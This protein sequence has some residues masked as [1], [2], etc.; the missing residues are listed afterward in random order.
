MPSFDAGYYQLT[1]LIPVVRGADAA[2]QW[3]WHPLS[4]TA[5]DSLRE[6]LASFRSVDVPVPSDPA[7]RHCRA[8]PFSCSNRTHFARLVVLE[9]L[10]YNG[11]QQGDTLFDTVRQLLPGMKKQQ[12]ES[13]DYLPSPYLLVLLDFDALDG[14]TAMVEKYLLELWRSMEQEWTLILRHC[15]G[16]DS[17]PERRKQSFVRLILNHEI[18]TTFGYAT[19]AWL[20]RKRNATNWPFPAG[21]RQVQD[22]LAPLISLL[23]WVLV[24]GLCGLALLAALF[25]LISHPNPAS[26]R[27]LLVLLGCAG[28]LV[29]LAPLLW[30]SLMRRANQPWS[31]EPFTDLRSILKALYLQNSFLEMAERWQNCCGEDDASLRSNFRSFLETAQPQNLNSPSLLPGHVC[32]IRREN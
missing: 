32:R 10:A 21:A 12:R 19:Y 3:R 9:D 18:E 25:A 1:A 29:L 17:T 8:I 11:L 5:V 16:F 28:G 13:P 14:S 24:V 22:R 27:H 30:Q 4:A 31:A 6:L 15:C 20:V 7:L 2:A 26:V 23:L